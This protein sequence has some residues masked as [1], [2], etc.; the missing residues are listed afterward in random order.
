ESMVSSG[1]L[2]KL[3][4]SMVNK[5]EDYSYVLVNYMSLLARL[6]L[7]DPEF[8]INFITIAGQQQGPMYN[9]KHLLNVILEI[10]LDKFDN[11]GHP[12]QRKLNAMAFATL[13]STTNPIILGYLAMFVAIW[14]DVL[15]EVKESGG[16]DALVYWQEE[17]ST[18]VGTDG[19]D[20][21]PE[22][23]RKRALLQRDP[24]HTTNLTQ[25]IRLKLGECETL[26]GGAQI[27]NQVDRTDFIF[28]D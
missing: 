25:F 2:G 20:D 13:I 4:D 21:T 23:K 19:V 22:T 8:I 17:I 14:G 15:S 7:I 10:W 28:E 1:L 9:D 18:E 6:I 16:G 27:F 24:I 12:K 3:I 11:I 5:N 26:N